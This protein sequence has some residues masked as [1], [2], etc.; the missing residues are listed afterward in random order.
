M[1]VRYLWDEVEDVPSTALV[2]E[3][4]S[5]TGSYFKRRSFAFGN[6]AQLRYYDY[7]DAMRACGYQIEFDIMRPWSYKVLTHG[8]L[9]ERVSIEWP[10]K[11]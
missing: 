11:K 7:E 9:V 5:G 1:T 10:R 3:I 6:E 4:I 2:H 8:L